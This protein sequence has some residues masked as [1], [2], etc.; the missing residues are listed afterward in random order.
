MVARTPQELWTLFHATRESA[1]RDRLVLQLAPVVERIISLMGPP[2][3]S[4]VEALAGYGLAALVAAVD[5][6]DPAGGAT[7]EQHAWTRVRA[8]VAAVQA[9]PVPL[10]LAS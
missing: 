1:F 8:A 9:E 3:S 10:L 7:V 2:D 5:S 4:S 6:Y